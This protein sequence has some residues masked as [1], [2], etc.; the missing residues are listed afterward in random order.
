MLLLRCGQTWPTGEREKRFTDGNW[1]NK[2]LGGSQARRL[3]TVVLASMSDM[4]HRTASTAGN[5]KK[6]KNI[7]L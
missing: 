4:S 3:S 1:S 6:K 7:M 5:S 2:S